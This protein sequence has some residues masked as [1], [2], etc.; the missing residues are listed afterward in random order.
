VGSIAEN[1]KRYQSETPPTLIVTIIDGIRKGDFPLLK[2]EAN[3]TEVE[4][5]MLGDRAVLQRSPGAEKLMVASGSNLLILG[6]SGTDSRKHEQDLQILAQ[7]A[8]STNFTGV[9]ISKFQ[10]AELALANDKAA[11][12]SDPNNFAVL[13]FAMNKSDEAR[14]DNLQALALSRDDPD[15]LYVQGVMDW[16]ST[17]SLRMKATAQAGLNPTQP[18]SGSDCANVK[19]ANQQ[20]VEEGTAALAKAVELRPNFSDTMAYL[21]LLYRERAAYECDDAVAHAADLKTDSEWFDK[22]IAAMKSNPSNLVGTN[23]ISMLPPPPPLPPGGL[24][25]ERWAECWGALAVRRRRT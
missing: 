24:R 16:V 9:A 19:A 7:E 14:S 17:Y 20:K 5:P 2:A 6:Y 12:E 21:N 4:L 3:T 13:L 22:T 10:V 18:L 15:V 8:I 23:Q 11:L 1:L 25:L